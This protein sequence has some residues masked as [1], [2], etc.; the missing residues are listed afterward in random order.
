MLKL[1]K[2][3]PNYKEVNTCGNCKYCFTDFENYYCNYDNDVSNII[4]LNPEWFANH[5][6]YQEMVCDHRE[7]DN[8]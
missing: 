2:I 6:T 3:R 5:R 8:K 1:K 4:V 7:Y